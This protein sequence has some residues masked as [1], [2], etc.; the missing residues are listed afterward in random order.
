MVEKM[1]YCKFGKCND[2]EIEGKML[3]KRV[4]Y[5]DDVAMGWLQMRE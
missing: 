4:R 2:L 3:Q 5:S 1:P